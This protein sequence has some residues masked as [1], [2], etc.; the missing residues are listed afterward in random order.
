MRR[1]NITI[2]FYLFLVFASGLAVGA[3]GYRLASVTPV[4]AKAS[5]KPASPDEWRTQYLSEMQ[6]R[7]KLTPDQVQKLNGILDDTRTKVRESRTSHDRMMKAIKEEHVNNVRE[8]LTAAQ[9]PEYEK[10]HAERE[11]RA[12][13]A[14]NNR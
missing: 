1:S 5:V 6:A 7:L 13:S 14:T 10:L 8:M 2:I 3:F 11:L 9:R 12:K 4:S